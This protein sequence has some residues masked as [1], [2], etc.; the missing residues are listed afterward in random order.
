M[1]P[2]AFPGSGSQGD[3]KIL[4]PVEYMLSRSTSFS[5]LP[6]QRQKGKKRYDIP[7]VQLLSKHF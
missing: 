1:D 4:L 2:F 5:Y 6:F 3:L 7:N